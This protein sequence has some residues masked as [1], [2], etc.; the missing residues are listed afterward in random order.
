MI[1]SILLLLFLNATTSYIDPL[2]WGAGKAGAGGIGTVL[3]HF[4]YM[5]SHSAVLKWYDFR[6]VLIPIIL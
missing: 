4:I 3:L 6:V 5:I 1:K 2:P